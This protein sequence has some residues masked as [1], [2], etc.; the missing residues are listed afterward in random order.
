MNALIENTVLFAKN[1]PYFMNVNETDRILLLKESAF[2]I[3]CV[4][5]ACYFINIA[6]NQN[7]FNNYTFMFPIFNALIKYELISNKMP[8][9]ASFVKI[10]FEFYAQ[11]N[12]IQLNQTEL[13]LFC[14]YLIFNSSKYFCF[15]F[16][17]NLLFFVCRKAE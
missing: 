8:Q 15:L 14:S 7:D 4:R 9:L 10:L 16:R 2:E 12:L 17:F 1:I 13:A 3:I 6:N 5:H 11:F